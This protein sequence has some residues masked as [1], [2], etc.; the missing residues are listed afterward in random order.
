MIPFVI[1]DFAF[2]QVQ[3]FD[4]IGLSGVER[5]LEVSYRG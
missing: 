1:V 2:I 4:S 3:V 5:N